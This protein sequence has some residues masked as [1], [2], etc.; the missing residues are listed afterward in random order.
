[1]SNKRGRPKKSN[2]GSLPEDEGSP[3]RTV[4]KTTNRFVTFDDLQTIFEE[5]NEQG[6]LFF[7]FFCF[8][9]MIN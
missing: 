2:R 4:K 5:T 1:M 7:C 3:P 6:I 9:D 8:I